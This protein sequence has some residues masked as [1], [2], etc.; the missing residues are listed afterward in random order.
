[1]TVITMLDLDG[2]RCIAAADEKVTSGAYAPRTSDKG[3]KKLY[4]LGQ[5]SVLG[6]TGHGPYIHEVLKKARPDGGADLEIVQQSLE[7]AYADVCR[8]KLKSGFLNRFGIRWKDVKDLPKNGRVG[9]EVFNM[10]RSGS[11][12]DVTFGICGYD[13]ADRRIGLYTVGYPGHSMPQE[14]YVVL[15]SGTDIA[16][17]EISGSLQK[18]SDHDRDNIEPYKGV[19]L[20]MHATRSAWR[21]LGVGGRTQIMLVGQDVPR[22][23]GLGESNFLNNLL[24]LESNGKVDSA[25]VDGVFQKVV[26]DNAKTS[27]LTPE[28][29]AKLQ[30][31]IAAEFVFAES[32]LV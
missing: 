32:L 17:L 13:N 12:F 30:C 1:M 9:K 10:L 20:L 6:F 25:Y 26:A 31:E 24:Y 5:N 14:K 16:Q 18:M 27:E 23:I 4:S 29:M 3:W 7:K 22:E 11:L 15:G 19:K 28:L 8:K 2:K 21:N